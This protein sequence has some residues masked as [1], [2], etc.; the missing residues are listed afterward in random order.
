MNAHDE[1]D[2]PRRDPG[3]VDPAEAVPEADSAEQYADAAEETGRE[4][5]LERAAELPFA[6]GSEGDVVE[7]TMEAGDEEED[8]YR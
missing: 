7:Q 4:D 3:E 6:E 8:E 2:E 5:W 1:T